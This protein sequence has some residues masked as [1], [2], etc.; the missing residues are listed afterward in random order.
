MVILRI[1]LYL[2]AK[3][4]PHLS[5]PSFYSTS[6]N[7]SWLY[8]SLIISPILHLLK[9]LIIASIYSSVLEG[10]YTILLPPLP[11]PM[12]RSSCSCV[13]ISSLGWPLASLIPFSEFNSSLVCHLNNSPSSTGSAFLWRRLNIISKS[14]LV[15]CG[16]GGTDEPSAWRIPQNYILKRLV[17]YY[18]QLLLRTLI[19]AL[20]QC[21][22]WQST[23]FLVVDGT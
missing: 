3:N 4:S 6:S 19:L 18:N 22:T 17:V 7:T 23:C 16:R 13:S 8:S 9:L 1:Y 14:S 15:I 2:L 20:E 12:I 11:L 21:L 10:K 5:S